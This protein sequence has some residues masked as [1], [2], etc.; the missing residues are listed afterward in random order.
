[1]AYSGGYAPRRPGRAT[2]ICDLA[3]WQAV[4]HGQAVEPYPAYGCAASRWLRQTIDPLGIKYSR[5]TTGQ[6]EEPSKN[7]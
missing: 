1:V 3:L 2:E 5:A 7:E 4:A 6:E